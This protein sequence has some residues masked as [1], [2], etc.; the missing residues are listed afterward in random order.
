MGTFG[1]KHHA[2]ARPA[3]NIDIVCEEWHS[4]LSSVLR[5]TRVCIKN[6]QVTLLCV[7]LKINTMSQKL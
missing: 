4:V 2:Y 6:Y 3:A 1:P 7:D 5:Y